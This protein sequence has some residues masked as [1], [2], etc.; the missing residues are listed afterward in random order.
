RRICRCIC[1]RGIC[2]CICG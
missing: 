1:G 2:R